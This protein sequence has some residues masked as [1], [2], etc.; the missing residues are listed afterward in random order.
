[1]P[2]S[3]SRQT[4]TINGSGFVSGATLTFDPPTGSNIDSSS[5]WLNFNSSSRITYQINNDNDAGTW[6]VRVN[7]PDGTTSS[8][9]S[10]TVN[11]ASTASPAISGVSPT[12]M[13][14]ST[15]RQTLTINGSNF[16]N[17]A[18][19]TFDPPT[20]SNINSSSSWLT[21]NSSSRIT[22][23]INNDNDAGTWQVR[24][25]N[26]DGRTSGWASFTVTA[27]AT[28]SPTITS[29]SPTSMPGSTSRQTLTINGSNFVSGATLTFDPPTGGNIESSSTWL[30][31]SSSSR[32][33]YQINNDNDAGNWL[34]R[35]TNPD[36]KTSGWTSFTVTVTATPSPTITGVSPASIPASSSDQ[37]LTING[38]GFVNGATL[39]FDPPTGGDLNSNASKLTYVSS[40]QI[41]YQINNDNDAG[42]WRVRVNNPDG[43]VSGWTSFTVAAPPGPGVFTLSNDPPYWDERSPAGPA[44]MLRW[45]QS[46]GAT[47][48]DVY[49]NG[50]L[51]KSGVGG[52]TFL[53]NANLNAG[54]IYTY[55]VVAR[56]ID[57]S[58]ESNSLGVGPMPGAPNQTD[59]PDLIV[60]PGSITF[61]PA[62]IRVGESFSLSFSIRNP[63]RG[64]AVATKARLR[65]SLDGTLTSRDA[66][67]AP[68][69]VDIPALAAGG[70]YPFS[71]QVQVPPTTL[72]GQYHVGVFADSTDRA[73]QSDTTNDSGISIARLAVAA[74]DQPGPRIT[75][76]PRSTSANVGETVTFS[77][78]AT[79]ED[80]SYQWMRF[81]SPFD[82]PD[83]LDSPTLTI[84]SVGRVN[85]GEYWVRVSSGGKFEDSQRAVIGVIG[86]TI[87]PRRSVPG[88]VQTPYG[89]FD[90][91]LPT[92]VLTH[93]W[94]PTG[95]YD[96]N[97]PTQSIADLRDAI[98]G[99][100]R[101]QGMRANI[102]V[103]TW[104]EAYTGLPGTNVGYAWPGYAFSY[105]DDHGES[106]ARFLKPLIGSRE[107]SK[108]I[109]FIGH[110]FGTFVNA[111]AAK[112]LGEWGVFVNQ[113]TILDSP[114]SSWASA[115]Y[116]GY[117]M[118]DY[119]YRRLARYKVFYVDNY[120]AP[121]EYLGF[122]KLGGPLISAFPSG[123]YEVP[124]TNHST[125]V[126][127]Y[128]TKTASGTENTNLYAN[129]SL[130]F[131]NSIIVDPYRDR[132]GT[133]WDPPASTSLVDFVNDGFR[134][135]FGSS[136]KVGNS[137]GTSIR[138]V[139]ELLSSSTN[140]E[141]TP[142]M[143]S[144]SANE[145]DPPVSSDARIEFDLVIP[146]TA[147][148]LTFDLNFPS[149]NNEDF[150]AVAFNDETIHVI[151][152]DSGE[153]GLYKELEASVTRFA[154][155]AGILS[156]TLYSTN[157]NASPVQIS[158]MRFLSSPKQS[159]PPLLERPT[160]L[161]V[162][163][164]SSSGSRTRVTLSARDHSVGETSFAFWKQEKRDGRGWK[165]WRKASVRLGT[166]TTG[167]VRTSFTVPRRAL[168][169]FRASVTDGRAILYSNS[170]RHKSR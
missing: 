110:S 109:H 119:F 144:H 23:Q 3:T 166:V 32:I 111:N 86:E 146:E 28:P 13:P 58:R 123:G 29:V 142:S 161:R 116:A 96:P 91:T 45:T 79:G 135:I 95:E 71:G 31:F 157:G 34:V 117:N 68:L 107:Y 145:S 152:S 40:G 18:T 84:A 124:Q 133:E 69:D 153:D 7:N 60:V 66:P 76:H 118:D 127:A 108:N 125:I 112:L 43:K 101:A 82:N 20:G 102:L 114:I 164:S 51:I 160:N 132:R 121:Q 143:V 37:T 165:S 136:R 81:S 94:Q 8:W 53:N 9:R 90:P 46:S 170:I 168:H 92:I 41:R 63:G 149:P 163:R 162:I 26:P 44:V 50:G 147:D 88:V 134:T 89:T 27:P 10:F 148:A 103:Y 156:V 65:L 47:S 100:L 122:A 61:S 120:Y 16:V 74:S 30:T 138:N 14:G 64:S 6:R 75:S 150:V 106:L 55:R 4:L 129:R 80:L 38:S 2:G 137:D 59:R 78:T 98:D 67:L 158:N 72:Q 56:N 62:T 167:T 57:G 151:N 104:R 97:T 1:M 128:Y 24:V 141:P 22:Y 159:V 169:R 115:G 25:T 42:T 70:T 126:T 12:S 52:L 154:G 17:G 15:S 77:V 39:T 139:I 35:V 130:G 99:R 48:Y 105:V 21:F 19:L 83:G 87:P 93:G 113:F 140:S 5:T 85:E 36:G 54:Q 73:D 33:T 155:T 11:A 49:R 131:H